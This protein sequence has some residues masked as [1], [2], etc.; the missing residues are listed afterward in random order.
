MANIGPLHIDSAPLGIAPDASPPPLDGQHLINS[1]RRKTIAARVVTFLGS[2]VFF[3]FFFWPADRARYYW[4]CAA[5]GSTQRRL[6]PSQPI[7]II[8]IIL[9]RQRA[10][11]LFPASLCCRRSRQ[12]YAR[13]RDSSPSPE[14]ITSELDFFTRS[15]KCSPMQIARADPIGGSSLL[16]LAQNFEATKE[17][18]LYERK[19]LRLRPPQVRNGARSALR[20]ALCVLRAAREMIMRSQLVYG[21]TITSPSIHS[22]THSLAGRPAA[23]SS[24]VRPL[25]RWSRA[26]TSLERH[27]N[28]AIVCA[29]QNNGA[30]ANKSANNRRKRERE[31]KH[32]AGR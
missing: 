28:D 11:V 2:R 17:P 27:L 9:G 26:E 4:I 19:L 14:R 10:R 5:A 31:R 32:S 7:R 20:S 6:L 23:V 25:V 18:Q 1:A 15:T 24:F 3:F 8:N 12:E 22:A 21:A 30:H 16:A 13:A 29:M